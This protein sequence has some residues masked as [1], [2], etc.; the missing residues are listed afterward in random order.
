MQY[1]HELGPHESTAEQKLLDRHLGVSTFGQRLRVGFTKLL[2]QSSQMARPDCR[3]VTKEIHPHGRILPQECAQTLV[4]FA[5]VA[6]LTS[7]YQVAT[8]SITLAD[9]GLNVI[10]SEIACLKDLATVHTPPVIP[11]KYLTT[12]HV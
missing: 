8:R 11:G 2:L 4:P 9:P 1:R 5:S 6:S 7:G 10:H 12:I 3:R